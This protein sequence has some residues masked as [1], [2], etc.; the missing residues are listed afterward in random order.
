MCQTF[1]CGES[2]RKFFLGFDRCRKAWC[3]PCKNFNITKQTLLENL[4][5]EGRK[6]LENFIKDFLDLSNKTLQESFGVTKVTLPRSQTYNV[7]GYHKSQK[8][9]SQVAYRSL[10]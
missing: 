3:Q 2:H 6:Y 7:K 1:S 9:R 10:N 5:H 4:N 8:C